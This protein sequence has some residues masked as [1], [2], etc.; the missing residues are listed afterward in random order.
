[1]AR[2]T[3]GRAGV[4]VRLENLRRTYGTVT[5]L[6][7]LDLHSSRASSSPCSARPGAA[8]RPRCACSRA[9]RTP[10]TGAWSW[11][12]RTSRGCRPTSATWAWCSR[13]TRCSRTSRRGRTSPSV[14]GCAGSPAERAQAAR[15]EMLELV[16]LSTQADRY[17]HQMSGGQQQRVALARALAIR[18][19]GPAPRRAALGARRQGARPAAR[20]DPPRAARGRD[21]DAV[22]HPRPGGGAR[23]RRPRRRHARRAARAGRPPGEVYA[24]PQTPF[25]AEFVGLSNRLEAQVSDGHA[26]RARGRAATR[27]RVGARGAGDGTRAPRGVQPRRGTPTARGRADGRHGHLHDVP[28]RRQP[29]PGRPRRRRHGAR[30]AVDGDAG[31][32]PPG[33]RVRLAL[34]RDPVLVSAGRCRPRRPRSIERAAAAHHPARLGPGAPLRAGTR[35]RLPRRRGAATASR[36]SSATTWWGGGAAGG[37][38]GPGARRAR[39][40]H[41]PAAGRRAVADPLRAPQPRLRGPALPQ[42]HPGAAA[43]GGAH[44]ARRRGHAAHPQPARPG[45]RSR[46]HRSSSSSPPATPSTTASGTSSRRSSGSRRR[47]G[48]ARLGRSGVRGG[49]VAVVA[50]RHLLGA[51]RAPR[52][53]GPVRDAARLP[54]TTPGCSSGPC[55]SS[56]REGLRLPWLACYGN[57]EGLNQGVG[58][59]TPSCRRAR[60]RPQAGAPAGRLRPRSRLRGVHRRSRGALPPETRRSR[61]PRQPS[62]VRAGVVEAHFRPEARPYGHGFT[63]ENRLAGRRTT[64][65]TPPR[66]R[67]VSLDTTCLA[68]G[69]DG[70]LD[71]PRRAG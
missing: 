9:S 53:T 28:G 23:H 58:A 64:P 18:P 38:R 66:A 8:R 19:Q 33:T 35:L 68:G 24:R 32:Y 67:L 29:R 51:R 11:P 55:A 45:A 40:R 16:G 62:G 42:D 44:R 39:A 27:R 25:V 57:H 21:H 54:R 70:C 17:A 12:A 4:E 59:I 50:G 13:P 60:R 10:T 48:A 49:A 34:R 20:R 2:E 63:E 37:R 26:R 65:T 31:D 43:P 36:T 6:D 69:A 46:A 15:G 5:A 56:P 52:R 71:P 61:R 30:P 22:R 3:A 7:G 41:R 14:C 1:M 47:A